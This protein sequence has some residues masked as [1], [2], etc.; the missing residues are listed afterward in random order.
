MT[1][2]APRLDDL[3][4][5]NREIAALVKAGVPLE[6]G[7]R[8]LAGSVGT[9]LG[10]LSERLSNRLAMGQSL[11][12]AL[13][14]EGPA[15]SPVYTAVMEAGL[16]SGRLPEALESMAVSGQVLQETRR[17]VWLAIL[18]PALCS[19]IAYLMFCLFI[20]VIAPQMIRAAEMFRFPPSWPIELLRTLHKHQIYATL[21]IPTAAFALL[22]GLI[23]LPARLTRI[24]LVFSRVSRFL[25]DILAFFPRS[26]RMLSPFGWINPV[27]FYQSL[28][29][30]QFTELLALQIEQG[31]P[32]PRA[33]LLA[34]ESTNDPR[35][36]SEARA[37]TDQLT[38][39]SSLV[40]A[41]KSAKSLPPLVNWMLATGEKQG[42]LAVTLR[43]LADM[44]RRR[45]LQ[46]A[47]TLRIWIPVVITICVTG[48]IG[49][50]YGLIFLIPMRALITGLMHE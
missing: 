18:Y 23:Y 4:L 34:A 5:L 36:H 9:R 3:I 25:G 29:W 31:S 6:L 7:L 17:R 14:E 19:V 44:Y 2:H 41:L 28:N 42:T 20:T 50:A 33:F 26:R 48:T 45:A 8:G 24:P 39:G 15:V 38:R 10:R 49:L 32:L 27:A 11:P 47:T 46:Q 12:D 37:V 13:A 22:V 16:A 40:D 1:P 35:W 43:Q 30:A 21:V